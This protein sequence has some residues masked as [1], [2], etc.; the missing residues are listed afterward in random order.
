LLLV[1]ALLLGGTALAQSKCQ[2]ACMASNAC[3]NC[4]DD[5][6]LKRCGS[7]QQDCMASCA[8]TDAS[9]PPKNLKLGACTGP[10]GRKIQCGDAPQSAP[11]EQDIKNML[12]HPK[13]KPRDKEK[14]EAKVPHVMPTAD[15]YQKLYEEH[16]K[17]QGH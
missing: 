12:A 10:G 3:T 17:Q 15:N 5:R 4:N 9:A 7:R 2:Q 16:Q 13:Q 11:N 6:C 8:K 14:D 1:T